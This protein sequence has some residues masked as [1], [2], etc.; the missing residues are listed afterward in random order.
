MLAGVSNP[1]QNSAQGG[2][3]GKTR[4]KLAQLAGVSH[5]TIDKVEEIEAN[6]FCF[7]LF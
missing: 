7:T 3:K 1:V 2:D 5:D 4:E 6:A